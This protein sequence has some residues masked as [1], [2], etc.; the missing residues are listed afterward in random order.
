MSIDRIL[1]LDL[2]RSLI[3]LL[4]VPYHAALIF[5]TWIY[6]S[7]YHQEK[8]LLVYAAKFSS[9]FRMEMFFFLAGFFSILII[10]K[11]GVDYFIN[12]RVTKLIIPFVTIYIFLCLIF[13]IVAGFKVYDIYSAF[14]GHLWFIY[15]LL[16]LIVLTL[17][18]E[19]FNLLYSVKFKTF[20]LAF[21]VSF[22]SILFKDQDTLIFY[23]FIVYLPSYLLGIFIFSYKND[24]KI[25]YFFLLIMFTIIL[26]IT[27]FFLKLNENEENIN[28][29][30]MFC[31]MIDLVVAYPIIII[32]FFIFKNL[33]DLKNNKFL[34]IMTE[35]S[36][37]I[38]LFHHPFVPFFAYIFDRKGINSYLLF[39]MTCGSTFI[40]CFLIFLFIKKNQILMNLF[41]VR[42]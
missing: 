28:S 4:S 1:G 24:I 23:S 15:T 18:L 2:L 40:V 5:G 39:F 26:L 41:S 31:D 33:I 37:Y 8:N 30:Y 13:S 38:Y 25:R 20:L 32:L 14:F 21:L 3:M 29:I 22:S 9:L 11:K 10:K 36:L 17:V 19:K 6:S 12:S 7:P 35:S 34:K 16:L 27:K 42:K